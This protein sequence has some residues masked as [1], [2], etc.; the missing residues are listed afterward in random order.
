MRPAQ[1]LVV[2]LALL[3][4]AKGIAPATVPARQQARQS[5][6]DLLHGCRSAMRTAEG[7][8]RLSTSEWMD[9]NGCLNYIT[10]YLAGFTDASAAYQSLAKTPLKFLC[11]PSGGVQGEELVRVVYKWLSEHPARLHEDQESV[12]MGALLDAYPC[13]A[14]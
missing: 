2:A 7:E 6:T 3:F 5:G 10:G 8:S 11:I 12:V 14:N 4:T 9:A 1:R 13:N